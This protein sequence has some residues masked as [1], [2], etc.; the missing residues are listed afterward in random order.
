MGVPR[1]C[2]TV[3]IRDGSGVSEYHHKVIKDM[4]VKC[5]QGFYVTEK[6]DEEEHIHAGLVFEKEQ[7]QGNVRNTFL[8]KF[9]EW[10]E[11]QKKHALCITH[12][13]N[14]EWYSKYCNKGGT[15]HFNNLD[16]DTIP[17]AAPDDS[18]DKKKPSIWYRK[19]EAELLA[20]ERFSPPYTEEVVLS[21]VNTL[22]NE[23]R[24]IEVIP[25]PKAL[26]Q[27]VRALVNFVNH[28]T[29]SRYPNK[30]FKT[31][32]QEELMNVCHNCNHPRTDEPRVIYRRP[33]QGFDPDLD[34]E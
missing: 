29:G 27:K 16:V 30:K 7:I 8:R 9:P 25:D 33:P 6:K 21:F 2:W 3:T 24:T 32:Y 5:K 34:P 19:R 11:H 14:L 28:Y 13:Y 10:N 23:D 26:Q 18:K 22:M 15:F 1:Q 4:I 31:E 17:F 20:D 12:W